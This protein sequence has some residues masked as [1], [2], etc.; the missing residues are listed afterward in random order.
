VSD[1]VSTEETV[2]FPRELD[3]SY[4]LIERAEGVW[5][6]DGDGASYLDAVGGGAMVASIGHGVREIVEAARVQAERV[7]FLYNQQFTT[8]A[9]EELARELVALAPPGFARVH[10]TS[11]GAEANETAVRLARSYHVERGEAGRWRIISPAQAYHGPTSATL[12]LAGRPALQRPYGPYIVPQLHIPPASWRFDPSGT[13]ALAALDALL[14]E[15]AGEIS[16]F[17]CEPVSAAALPAYSPPEAFWHGLAERRERHGFLIVL[18]EVV[19]GMGR[20]GT[21]FAADQLPLVPDVITTSKGLGA[22]YANVGAVLCRAEVFDAVAAG[23]RVFDLGHTWDGAPLSCAVGL[24]VVRY[25]REHG[26]VERV[27]SEGPRVLRALA[28]A[29]ADS[30]LVADVRG[31]GFLFGVD[32]ADPR[33]GRSFLPPELGVARR[34]DNEALAR[35]L[36]VYSTQPTA[37]GYAG[38]QTLV[39]PAF[40]STDEELSLV[41]E[42]LAEAVFAVER[43]VKDRLAS[44][45]SPVE[46]S[47]RGGPSG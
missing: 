24:A 19:T 35:G 3:R 31:R 42:R 17:L 8:P 5:L 1:F 36:I 23:S 2:V 27:Q 6:Y 39:A 43:E 29:L 25:L 38:D 9:Q 22:G 47:S 46:A 18:D 21:W 16:A 13:E 10:F 15:H 20:T 11:G 4:P 12:G 37:D 44:P 7:S 30:E 32:Y 26:L 41:V 28:A 40:T 33:D 34:I 45:P 14:E